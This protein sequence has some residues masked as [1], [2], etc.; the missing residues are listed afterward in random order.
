MGQKGVYFLS[1][2]EPLTNCPLRMIAAFSPR[3]IFL[4]S[5]LFP[6]RGR[7]GAKPLVHGLAQHNLHVGSARGDVSSALSLR[8]D[9][10][11]HRLP[12]L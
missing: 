12:V 5:C 3:R 1:V 7:R 8:M 9:P 4:R 10:V 2:S 11:D 6:A